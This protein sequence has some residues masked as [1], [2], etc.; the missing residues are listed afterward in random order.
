MAAAE[1]FEPLELEALQQ[2][3]GVWGAFLAA[4]EP[5]P[6][7]SLM[8][9]AQPPLRN[10]YPQ[11]ISFPVLLAAFRKAAKGKRREHRQGPDPRGQAPPAAVRGAQQVGTQTRGMSTARK[12]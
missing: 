10:F 7:A 2:G 12:N 4:L 9:K 8:A 6:V 11:I 5:R 1:Q 3:P